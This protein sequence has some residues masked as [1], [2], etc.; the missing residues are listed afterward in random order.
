MKRWKG[1]QKMRP[2]TAS[3]LNLSGLQAMYWHNLAD[4]CATLITTPLFSTILLLLLRRR[5]AICVHLLPLLYSLSSL[6]VLVRSKL[7]WKRVVLCCVVFCM[8]VWWSNQNYSIF[9]MSNI[10]FSW[11]LTV[12]IHSLTVIY[13]VSVL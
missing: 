10:Y 11:K 6:D 9:K 4:T 3:L 8:F 2:K 7:K 12:V 1:R 13:E 5:F